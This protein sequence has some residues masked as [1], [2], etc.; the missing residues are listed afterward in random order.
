MSI[1]Y[2]PL[3][4]ESP[5]N[6]LEPN[7]IVESSE[8]GSSQNSR[9]SSASFGSFQGASTPLQEAPTPL[10][11]WDEEFDK[12][13]KGKNAGEL[14]MSEMMGVNLDLMQHNAIRKLIKE[15]NFKPGV[16]KATNEGDK[17]PSD[18][19]KGGTYE[20]CIFMGVHENGPVYLDQWGNFFDKDVVNNNLQYVVPEEPN[21]EGYYEFKERVLIKPV[22]TRRSSEI[23]RN[24]IDNMYVID[25][26][27][28]KAE[29]HRQDE[30]NSSES[31]AS[32]SLL[33]WKE[34]QTKIYNDENRD[35]L[36]KSD[37]MGIELTKKQHEVIEY[38]IANKN[39]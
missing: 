12:D 38:L 9:S 21:G 3:P 36:V 35:K 20:Y 8:R 22:D 5:R 14:I 15:N 31:G 17:F 4:S 32:K 23:F 24:K 13:Y 37:I 27:F 29:K 10:Q 7:L 25:N 26:I 1:K 28:D 16:W 19:S 18:C 34:E 6:S 33:S 39:F 30:I 2:E 11:A